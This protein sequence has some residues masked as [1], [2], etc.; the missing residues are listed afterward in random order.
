VAVSTWLRELCLESYAQAF[1]ANDVDAEVLPRLTAKDLIALGI[2]SIGHRRKLLH[3]IDAF[4]RG[5][6]PAAE[7]LAATV[8]PLGML[9]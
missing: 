2:T 6:P 3:A 8:Q 7:P 9:R 5:R 4:D 1:R